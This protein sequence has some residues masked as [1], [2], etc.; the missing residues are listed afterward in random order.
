MKKLKKIV[1]VG[2]KSA[3]H[4][5]PCLSKAQQAYNQGYAIILFTSS[6]SLD[7][8]IVSGVK[9]PLIH[10]KLSFAR[11]SSSLVCY[12]IHFFQLLFNTA[13][14]F[15][16]LIIHKPEKIIST[17]GIY[18]IPVCIAGYLLRIPIHLIEPNAIP[19][20]AMR[21]LAILSTTVEICFPQTINFLPRSRCVMSN[22]PVRFSAD[23]LE[24]S[25]EIA[26]A[27]LQLPDKKI[28]LV[29]GGSQGSHYINNLVIELFTNNPELHNS[30]AIVH[31]TGNEQLELVTSFYKTHAL[32]AR[33]FSYESSMH[34]NY[35]ASDLI[36]ARAG[37]GTLFEINAFKKNC[38]I[39]PLEGAAHNHQ[40]NNAIAFIE[41]YSQG[42][43]VRQNEKNA[44]YFIYNFMKNI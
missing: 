32:T 14:A 5:M 39:I 16:Q 20:K 3:G 33:V 18:S 1:Y 13:K 15:K 41:F 2:G 22:Y 11:I 31:Q 40:V 10:N 29:L 4:I 30:W 6:G 8:T 43:L 27:Q 24:I 7:T 19:G 37:A 44:L 21:F 35:A 23:Q 17:G 36:I 38:I 12:V 34:L 9:F 26:L 42:L 28:L 25:K